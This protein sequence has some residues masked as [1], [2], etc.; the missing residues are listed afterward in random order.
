MGRNNR[1]LL[2][3]LFLVVLLTAT[4]GVIYWLGNLER[5]RDVYTI[6]TQ[7]S[8]SGLNPESTVFFR[9][10]AVGKVLNIRF[11]P[12]NA[13]IILVG[14]EI[15]KNIVLTKGVYATLHLKGV[16]GLTQL[17][18]G[19]AG[20]ITEKLPPGN[21]IAN[22]IPLMQS[23]TDR[24]LNSGDELL[25]KADHLMIRLSS[26]LNEENE[27]NIVGILAN[28]KTL[29]DKLAD[30]QKSVEKALVGIPSLTTDARKTLTH[31][32]TLAGDLQNL[33][34]EARNLSKKVSVVADT[35]SVA[36]NQLV[37]TTLPKVN[38][39]L[40]DLQATTEQVKKVA[41]ILE[42]NPQSVLLGP[43]QQEPGP[44]EPGFEEPK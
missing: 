40:A 44:G 3:G 34:K 32:D 38:R 41:N 31:I 22:R 26:L 12:E 8:V 17:E 19:D 9:G 37:Q 4:T 43:E 23:V 21:N 15:D 2:T 30:L 20:E 6:S 14:I 1:A 39:L 35:G 36:G 10:I 7:A 13:G 33:S 27:K 42:H 28:L 18:L 16:T 25:K 5:E 29:S 24:L 11:D